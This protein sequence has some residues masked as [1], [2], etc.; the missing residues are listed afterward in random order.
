MVVAVRKPSHRFALSQE[1]IARRAAAVREG[2][3]AQEHAD[4]RGLAAFRQRLLWECLSHRGVP[5]AA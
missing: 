4:R 2:W 1:Q 3:S 5:T